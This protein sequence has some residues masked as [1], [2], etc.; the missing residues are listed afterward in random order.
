M[1]ETPTVT[2]Q[3]DA[4]QSPAVL[5]AECPHCGHEDVYAQSEEPGPVAVVCTSCGRA[6]RIEVPSEG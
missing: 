1:E 3:V 5:V 6:F 4:A 2:G